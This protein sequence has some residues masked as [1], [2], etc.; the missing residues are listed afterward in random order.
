MLNLL[1]Q[2]PIAFLIF[3]AG[4]LLSISIHEFAHCFITDKLGDPTPRIK[5]RLTLNP[6]AHLD[7][8]GTLAIILT[9]FGWGKPA[10]Y[11]PYNLKE[12]VRDAALI[13]AA[14]PASNLL[15]ATLFSILVKLGVGG[16]FVALF[17]VQ[18][19]FINV[20]LALFNLIPVYPLDGGKIMRAILPQQASLE[21]EDIMEHYGTVILIMMI[22]PW[23]GGQSAMSALLSPMINTLL[24]IFI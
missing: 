22:F 2:N 3:M 18:L 6:L 21:Y 5:G 23:V 8:V 24:K 10:P 1:A 4:L 7:P 9:G 13:A 11:D 16:D 12:P 20:S 14:G 19:I 15:I 17:A